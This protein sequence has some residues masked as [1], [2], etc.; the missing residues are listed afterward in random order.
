MEN[1]R[2]KKIW[3]KAVIVWGRKVGLNVGDANNP[4]IWRLGVNAISNKMR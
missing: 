3:L 2:L 4:S 1:C